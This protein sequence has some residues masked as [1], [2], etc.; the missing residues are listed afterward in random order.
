MVDAPKTGADVEALVGRT[1]PG[2]ADTVN[3]HLQPSVRFLEQSPTYS[4]RPSLRL[5][6]GA[7]LA[8]TVPWPHVG[9]RPLHV[10]AAADLSQIAPFDETGSLPSTGQLHFFFDGL[11]G[12]FD[13]ADP[14]TAKVIYTDTDAGLNFPSRFR[15]SHPDDSNYA[16]PPV[17]A[18]LACAQPWTQWTIPSN[19]EPCFAGTD[20]RRDDNADRPFWRRWSDLEPVTYPTPQMLGWP[21]PEQGS[22]AHELPATVGGCYSRCRH[23]TA[24][25]HGAT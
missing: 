12:A 3:R 17:F 21:T 10:V 2:F 25:S 8:S 20:W 23:G 15:T 9:T 19:D 18:E 16:V 13:L 6:G 5:G 24:A 22:M 1:L 4:G 7:A 14:A 11:A